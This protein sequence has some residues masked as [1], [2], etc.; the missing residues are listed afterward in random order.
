[1]PR[2]QRVGSLRSY[3]RLSRQEPLIF[4]PSS[5]SIILTRLSGPRSG[6]I[7]SQIIWKRR[8]SNQNQWVPGAVSSGVKLT[9]HFQVVRRSRK[10]GSVH[11]LPIRPRGGVLS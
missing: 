9:T 6:P 5:S 4:L 1:V 3:S 11:P 8:E 7:T 2:G 10:R